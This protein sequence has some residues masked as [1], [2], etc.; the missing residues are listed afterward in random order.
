MV[1]WGRGRGTG[2]RWEPKAVALYL[3]VGGGGGTM[4]SSCLIVQGNVDQALYFKALTS[5]LDNKQGQNY[6]E[7]GEQTLLPDVGWIRIKILYSIY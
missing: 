7:A 3:P 1:E 5:L 6:A 2:Y 4:L